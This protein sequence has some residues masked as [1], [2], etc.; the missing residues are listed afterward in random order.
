[1]NIIFALLFLI[2]TPGDDLLNKTANRYARADGIQWSMESV[3]YSPV[4]EETETTP[5][6][7]NF[8]SPD[9]FYF[10]SP[11]EE[12][13]GI[14]DTVWVLSKKHKQIQ[15]KLSD[16]YTSPIDLIVKWN[17]RYDLQSYRKDKDGASFN[18]V[19]HEGISPREVM[20]VTGKKGQL[21]KISYKD[22]SD[23]NVTMNV[24]KERLA[25]SLSIDYFYN[26]VPK[27]YRLIDMTE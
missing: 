7:F 22:S 19:G 4:F 6:Q 21:K 11:N 2:N 12:V 25:R 15:K 18:L 5:V 14:A 3:V 9:T 1:M 17:S 16:S 13:L 8:N 10:K 24:K 26:D 27:D 23:N 20:I